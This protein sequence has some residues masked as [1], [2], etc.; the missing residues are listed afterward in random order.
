MKLDRIATR[1]IAVIFI[2]PV[3]LFL[4]CCLVVAIASDGKPA[5][6]TLSEGEQSE[7][8]QVTEARAQAEQAFWVAVQGALNSSL[9]GCEAVEANA[10]QKVAFARREAALARYDAT[11]WKLRA[12]KQ[13]VECELSD[14]LK[15]LERKPTPPVVTPKPQ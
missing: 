1:F 8:K 3:F 14:D 2:S 6:F 13:C 9:K 5:T 15:S 10:T 7:V 11:L 4:Y 12:L